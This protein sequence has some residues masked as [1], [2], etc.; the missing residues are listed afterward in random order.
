MDEDITAQRRWQKRRSRTTAIWTVLT[1]IAAVVF[2][3]RFW[4][5]P[6][7]PC[8]TGDAYCAF[9]AG[10]LDAGNAFVEFIL[11]VMWPLVWGVGF[12]V[13]RFVFWVIGP[14]RRELRE[15]ARRRAME[16]RRW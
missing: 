11:V 12:G 14:E 16:P 7:A 6:A 8:P 9:G 2:D 10:A 15:L 3:I 5:A 13:I 4:P 1:V